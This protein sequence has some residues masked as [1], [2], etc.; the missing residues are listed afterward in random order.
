MYFSKF[1]SSVYHHEQASEIEAFSHIQTKVVN[2]GWLS[3]IKVLG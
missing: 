3:V 1:I 2:A